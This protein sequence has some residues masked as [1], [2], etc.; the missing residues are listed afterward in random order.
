MKK[1]SQKGLEKQEGSEESLSSNKNS[2]YADKPTDTNF[3]QEKEKELL[4]R[5]LRFFVNHFTVDTDH[6]YMTI[7]KS[8]FIVLRK[9]IELIF[10]ECKKQRDADVSNS[11]ISGR[12]DAHINSQEKHQ[13]QLQELLDF[14]ERLDYTKR[15][16]TDKTLIQ[17]DFKEK[18]NKKIKPMI[19]NTQQL[20]S[21]G[22][23]Q[24]KGVGLGDAVNRVQQDE[25]PS[26]GDSPD[27]RSSQDVQ[28]RDTKLST[29]KSSRIRIPKNKKITKNVRVDFSGG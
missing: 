8:D 12:M 4:D 22:G 15:Q 10:K 21:Q 11:Y 27:S 1:H 2:V 13:K 29:I 20:N 6:P 25:A 24:T 9:D 16:V 26:R 17:L 19:N 7:H 14:V 5:M 23:E 28:N 3:W 18:I